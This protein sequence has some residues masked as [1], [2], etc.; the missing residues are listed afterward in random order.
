ME[1][2]LQIWVAMKHV[3]ARDSLE[4]SCIA[5]YQVS[6]ED[7][8]PQK[9]RPN[10]KNKVTKNTIIGP[11]M[12]SFHVFS[13]HRFMYF[14]RFFQACFIANVFSSFWR[15][16]RSCNVAAAS[17]AKIANGFVS[18]AGGTVSVGS[19]IKL[20]RSIWFNHNHSSIVVCL[21]A[22]KEL[23]SQV[24]PFSVDMFPGKLHHFGFR[25][26]GDSETW[27]VWLVLV[28]WI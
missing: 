15:S 24:I 27:I 5:F 20:D 1:A 6:T 7:S 12:V 4:D 16:H 8:E 14:A 3:C 28:M 13:L 2:A 18:K 26:S 9:M 21:L 17:L 25:K 11:I 19:T 10:K 22:L 23:L